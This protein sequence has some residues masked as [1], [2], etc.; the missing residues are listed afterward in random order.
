M[1]T[2]DKSQKRFDSSKNIRLQTWKQQA[3]SIQ[4]NTIQYKAYVK[5]SKV[6]VKVVKKKKNAK[7]QN[8]YQT[9]YDEIILF[10]KNEIYVK[11]VFFKIGLF[12]TRQSKN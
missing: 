3:E 10:W 4:Y 1:T 12:Y 6:K 7:K 11:T 5:L 9:V 2:G 8:C